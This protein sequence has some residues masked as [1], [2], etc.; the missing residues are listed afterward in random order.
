[1]RKFAVLMLPCLVTL[2]LAVGVKTACAANTAGTLDPTFGSGGVAV[3]NF[4]SSGV[5]FVASV[6]LQSDGKILVLTQA[7]STGGELL[8]FTS[9]GALDTSFGT[10]GAAPLSPPVN[11]SMMLQPNGQIVIA[12]VITNPSTG[13]AELGV[14]R[15]NAN[16]TPDTSFGNGG[17]AT[18]SLQNRAPGEGLTVLVE[19]T[20]NIL[21]G[22]QLFPT[23]RRQPTQTILVRFTSAG[24]PEATFAN[25]GTLI[26]TLSSGCTGLAE[27][28]TQ[29]IVVIDG[30]AIAQITPN[31]TVESTVTGGTIIASNNDSPN[32]APSAFRSNGD[33][34]F[35]DELFV[36]EESRGHN[37]SVQ[38]F[39]F[40]QTGSADPGFGD[41]SFHF[42]GP[43]G[44]GIEAIA[45]AMASEPN[46]DIVVVG[47]Q[48][49]LSRSGSATVNGLAR[50]TPGGALDT[51]FGNGGTVANSVPPAAQ[52]L[53]AIAIQPVDGKIVT[54]GIANNGT[55]LAVSRYLGQ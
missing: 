8:R 27:L 29:E 25:Q 36:G 16:G 32:G 22:T 50:L 41:P 49:T 31:G 38:V 12:G 52:G 4:G 2:G 30:R 54:I 28:S 9:G 55:E 46:G 47:Q 10:A 21:V 26:A 24:A 20:G 13:A 15:L 23:G 48:T 34:L 40:T 17:L 51:T 11:G 37:S 33:Y 45:N 3:I 14:E 35:A 6:A 44:S 42:Q 5:G 18:A 19:S 1:M 39:R 7:G 43:G 53:V